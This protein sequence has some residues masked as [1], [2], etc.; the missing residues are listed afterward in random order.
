MRVDFIVEGEAVV[1]T[2]DVDF[3]VLGGFVSLYELVEEVLHV[4]AE[5]SFDVGVSVS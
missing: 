5:V 4:E 1:F 3:D 2:V